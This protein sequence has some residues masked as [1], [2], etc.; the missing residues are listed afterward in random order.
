MAVR[1]VA[2]GALDD[3]GVGGHAAF[4]GDYVEGL[5]GVGGWDAVADGAEGSLRNQ[6][7]VVERFYCDGYCGSWRG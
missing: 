2:C 7:G 3:F 6:L 5:G 1:D 4:R